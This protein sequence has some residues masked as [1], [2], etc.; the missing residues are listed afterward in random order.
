MQRRVAVGVL[1]ALAGQGRATGG[2]ADEEAARELVGHRPD[3]VARALEAEHRVEDVERDHVLA[4]RGVRRPGRGRRRHRARLG[5]ALVE[6][7]ALRGLLVGEQH[8]AVD[9]LVLLAA[10]VVDLGARE[11]RVHAERAVLVGRDRDEAVA[12]LRVLHPVAQ[13]ADDGHRGGELVLARALLELGVELVAG[14]L[15]RGGPVDAARHRAAE[16]LAALEHVLD[17]GGVGAR[18]VERRAAGLLVGLLEVAVAD[19]QVE[20]V[21]ELLE[22]REGQLLHLVGGVLALQ[23]VDRPALDGVGEDHRRLA[24]VLGRGVEG[25]VHLA[26]VVATA[27]QLL[28][29]RVRHV[30]DHLAQARVAAEE[31][32][33]D[34]GA[35]LGGVGLELP[36]G[37]GVHPVDQDAVDVLGE[38]GVPLAAP[39]DLDDVPAGAAEVGLEL[40]DDLAVAGD[41]AVELLQV[42]VDDPGEVVELLARGDADRAERLG[43]G[44]LAVAHEGPHA[45]LLGVLDAA[46]VAGSG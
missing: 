17:L 24:G 23:R 30:L 37:R 43:L 12:D 38:Q 16:G 9:R 35:V 8:L 41:R 46:V 1:E 29:L 18:V 4:V 5:D 26:V 39:D 3:R 6:H 33:A 31:V 32:L 13:Q 20:P 36:V 15:E 34:V 45:L 7:L 19:R 28:D 2:G 21:A 40:L 11:H 42:A 27:R 44:H 10:R 14:Q 25:G 22:V